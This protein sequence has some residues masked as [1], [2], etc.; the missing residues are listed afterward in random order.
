M[1]LAQG[2][3][4]LTSGTEIPFL[5]ASGPV[6]RVLYIHFNVELRT[7][8]V[9]HHGANYESTH[10]SIILSLA[11][12]WVTCVYIEYNICPLRKCYILRKG[13]MPLSPYDTVIK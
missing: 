8:Q 10:A 12:I 4:G 13:F 6:T 2:P 11:C 3:S 7:S 5:A 1:C 9:N